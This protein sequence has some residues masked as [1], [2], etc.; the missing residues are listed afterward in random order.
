M[1]SERTTLEAIKSMLP[2]TPLFLFLSNF[3]DD[4]YNEYNT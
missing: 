4:D 2:E 3:F 1:I